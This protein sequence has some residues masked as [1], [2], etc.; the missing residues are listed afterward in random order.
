MSAL[1]GN[2]RHGIAARRRVVANGKTSGASGLRAA[3]ASRLMFSPAPSAWAMRRATKIPS[4]DSGARLAA[5]T[6]TL[7]A[8]ASTCNLMTQDCQCPPGRLAAR[9]RHRR[10]PTPGAACFSPAQGRA[11]SMRS[12]ATKSLSGSRYRRQQQRPSASRKSRCSRN[13]S[14]STLAPDS[15][16][17]VRAHPESSLPCCGRYRHS[18]VPSDASCWAR[19]SGWARAG[20]SA[21]AGGL[22]TRFGFGSCKQA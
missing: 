21:I 22:R 1:G 16:R 17:T 19:G 13:P 4:A 9:R 7:G 18:T 12:Q 20:R 14:L 2:Q 8:A 3:Q 6:G 11:S 10:S 5:S 15:T